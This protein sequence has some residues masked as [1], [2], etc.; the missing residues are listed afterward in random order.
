MLEAE[1]SI[2]IPESHAL[3][4][5]LRQSTE[6]AFDAVG[7]HDGEIIDYVS[8]MLCQFVHVE[9]LY[10]R[11]RKTGGA[12]DDM[13]GVKHDPGMKAGDDSTL[14]MVTGILEGE[15][16]DVVLRDVTTH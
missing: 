16:T 7:Y 15:V 11:G 1:K 14:R 5:H 8:K 10:R 9:N 4:R 2:P 13:F 12:L 6:S 3:G